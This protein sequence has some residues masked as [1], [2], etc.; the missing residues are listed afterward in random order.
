MEDIQYKFF[1][2]LYG[3]PSCCVDAFCASYC[4][5]TLMRHPNG[6]WMGTGYMPC[7]SCAP[8]A[9]QDFDRFVAERIAPKRICPLP[10]PS[11][12]S[13]TA[14][15]AALSFIAELELDAIEAAK[16]RLRGQPA[17]AHA[18]QA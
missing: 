6:P 5:E 18:H 3:F 9:A 8:K 11:E 13:R 14:T 16:P 12:L 1:G 7:S 4:R 17:Y 15:D 2:A 10:F